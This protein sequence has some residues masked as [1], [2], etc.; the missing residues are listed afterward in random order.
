MFS[1]EMDHDEVKIVIMDD[2][3]YIPDL[4]LKLYDDC[5]FLKQVVMDPHDG[6]ENEIEIMITPAMF[7]EMR[8]SFEKSNGVYQAVPK[9]KTQQ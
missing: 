7:D 4:E 9:R 2:Y 8:T 5:V 3:G 6:Y 1:V